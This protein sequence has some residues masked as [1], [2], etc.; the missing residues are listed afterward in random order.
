M[1]SFNNPLGACT[2]CEGYGKVIGI[3]EDLVIPNRNLSVYEDAVVCWKGEVM[4]EWKQQLMLN[5]SKAGFPV[6]KPI[7]KL[8][9]SH[10]DMLWYGC[11]YFQGINAFFDFVES[12]QYKIQYRVMLARYR[13]KTICP[14]CKGTRLRKEASFVKVGG[15]PIQELVTMPIEKLKKYFDTLSFNKSDEKIAKRLLT[16]INSRIHFLCDVGL[17]YLTLN[18]LS[19]T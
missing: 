5:A 3:D 11:R 6:H 16:E 14:E 4:G 15:K 19:N 13:G 8:N 9:E 17:G 7:Y 2:R 10:Y 18:R 12:Q 1:F